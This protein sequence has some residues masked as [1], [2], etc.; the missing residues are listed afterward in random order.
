MY[1]GKNIQLIK[2]QEY[3]TPHISGSIKV[4]VKVSLYMSRKRTGRVKVWLHLFL[5][6]AQDGNK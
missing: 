1:Y 5:A 3:D 2:V 4:K 6:M